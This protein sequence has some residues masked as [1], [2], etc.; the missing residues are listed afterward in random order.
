MNFCL[1]LNIFLYKIFIIYLI[2][3]R[4]RNMNKLLIDI[5]L[6]LLIKIFFLYM[7][8]KK[9]QFPINLLIYLY[10]HFKYFLKEI[11]LQIIS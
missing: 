4:Y 8:Q 3:I 9:L 11:N 10:Y 1:I 7:F 2:F 6:R 5:T